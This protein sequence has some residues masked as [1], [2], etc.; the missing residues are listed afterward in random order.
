VEAVE[1]VR[2]LRQTEKWKIKQ[3]LRK[4]RRREWG[5]MAKENEDRPDGD[6]PKDVLVDQETSEPQAKISRDEEPVAQM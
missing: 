3:G 6:L 5:E 2:R 4:D 1:M